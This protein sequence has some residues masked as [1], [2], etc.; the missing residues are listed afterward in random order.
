MSQVPTAFSAPWRRSNGARL[1]TMIDQGVVSL[2]GVLTTIFLARGLAPDRFGDAVIL[3][4]VMLFLNT[5][6]ASLVVYPL[7]VRGAPL[8]ES[9]F[10]SLMWSS[11]SA[12]TIV[13][14]PLAL[15]QMTI[16]L[17]FV[18][19]TVA[20]LSALALIAW[21]VQET[22]RRA[23][24]TRLHHGTAISG[25]LLS[26]VGQAALIGALVAGSHLTLAL[27]FA[28]MIATSMIGGCVQLAQLR[29]GRTRLAIAL[30]GAAQIP[31]IGKWTL[32][33]NVLGAVIMQAPIWAIA[34]LMTSTAAGQFQA[35][36][37]IVG[38]T[39][40]VMYGVA[41][42]LTPAVARAQHDL[43]SPS[44][45]RLATISICGG[46][47]LLLPYVVVVM[48]WPGRILEIIYGNNS[49][50]AHLSTAL[51]LL[52]IA[53]LLVYLAHVGNAVLFGLERLHDVLIVQVAGTIVFL[54]VGI[55]AVIQWGIVGVAT[56]IIV[57]HG[58]RTV[59][60][61]TG[62]SQAFR[63]PGKRHLMAAEHG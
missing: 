58:V 7:T 27:V 3:V 26:Y 43:S 42:L 55:P 40:P 45:S 2:G 51:R 38:V 33:S 28:S 4:A 15:V 39:N 18:S 60:S 1:W 36:L 11:L 49:A 9:S 47:L 34:L 63:L 56:S 8:D 61:A 21:Q 44:P 10:R 35:M 13:G 59:A 46:I 24:F 14:I 23:L 17:V 5:V 48:V 19:T 50:Y 29:P 32:P 53:Y 41:N 6:H 12:T 54:I 62:L 25:D 31:Q 57:V 30:R 16:A 22:A 52:M 37:T 20:A